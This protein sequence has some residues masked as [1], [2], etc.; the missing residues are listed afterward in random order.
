MCPLS[1]VLLP[2]THPNS[3][4]LGQQSLLVCTAFTGAV[5][6]AAVAAAAA[7]AVG[8]S[9][10]NVVLVFWTLSML[11]TIAVPSMYLALCHTAANALSTAEC[12]KLAGFVL[13]RQHEPTCSSL[14][15]IA[16]V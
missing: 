4:D 9:C 7:A 11:A 2:C 15:C 5:A 12:T 8:L 6:A 14:L 10:L 16:C 1:P 13:L 3:S